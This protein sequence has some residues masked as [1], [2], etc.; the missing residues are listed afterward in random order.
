MKDQNKIKSQLI[1]ELN[2]SETGCLQTENKCRHFFNGLDGAVFVHDMNGQILYAN[3]E[4]CRRY[5]YISNKFLT[6]QVK[7]VDTPEQAKHIEER[8]Q[9][10]LENGEIKFK[11]VHLDSNKRKIPTEVIAKLSTY[12]WQQV[13]LVICHDII[14]R[15]REEKAFQKSRQQL[16]IL[17]SNLPGMAYRCKND[18]DWTMEFVSDG[19]QPL[20]GYKPEE[21]VGNA[22]LSYAEII[23]P[24]DRQMV[25]DDIQDAIK[26][27]RSFQLVYRIITA[28]RKEK[29]V[30]E[31][32]VFGK[33]G[34]FIGI[35]GFIADITDRRNAPRE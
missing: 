9:M 29:W 3:D 22:L 18:P 26:N 13:V 5:G 10:L 14:E 27:K 31:Q 23:H 15:K 7:D 17:M 20:T 4:A 32:G 28:N 1:A 30:W 21:L 2:Q 16:S 24:Q 6:M 12:D 35:E 25:W 19:C 11:T 34:N 8:I 33:E